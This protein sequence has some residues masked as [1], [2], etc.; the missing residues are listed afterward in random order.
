MGFDVVV[1]FFSRNQ[2][3]FSWLQNFPN[4]LYTNDASFYKDYILNYNEKDLLKLKEKIENF[5]NIKLKFTKDFMKFPK[6]INQ[7][8]YDDIIFE[9]P[10][11]NFKRVI[12]K[13]SENNCILCM[14]ENKV[15]CFN[16]AGNIDIKSY[17]WYI[18]IILLNFFFWII[19]NALS[20]LL[21]K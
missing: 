8:E 2:N 7:K 14:N 11:P 16:F 19:S 13:N 10:N 18:T 17:I 20:V 4:A 12:I 15:P 21:S 3:H 1:L 6:F 9:E 5:Y